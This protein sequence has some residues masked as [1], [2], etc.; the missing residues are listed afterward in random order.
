M[1]TPAY[2][3]Y[4]CHKP[5]TTGAVEV[6]QGKR[7]RGRA[8]THGNLYHVKCVPP[9]RLGLVATVWQVAPAQSDA[10]ELGSSL[11][12]SST[13]LLLPIDPQWTSR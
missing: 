13:G 7:Y 3:C 1:D 6:P 10:Q 11:R 2:E 12:N 5:I 4:R 8:T 9:N